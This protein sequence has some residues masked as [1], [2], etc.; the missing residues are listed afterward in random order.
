M[1]K[2]KKLKFETFVNPEN[3][4]LF[5]EKNQISREDVL[6]VTESSS[7]MESTHMKISKF[8]LFYWDIEN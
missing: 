6:S 2:K 5:I 7:E 4:G 3:I 1:K 8:T